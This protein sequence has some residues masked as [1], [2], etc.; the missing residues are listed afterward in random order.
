MSPF[1]PSGS[2]S[3]KK[4]FKSS[5]GHHNTGS[6]SSCESDGR[7]FAALGG[8]RRSIA[9]FGVLLMGIAA[10][11]V[12]QAATYYVSNAGNDSNSGTS[13]ASPWKSIAKLNRMLPGFE[14]GRFRTA[15]GW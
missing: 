9:V 5:R 7:L 6:F 1:Q 11:R 3:P 4:H 2:L 15:K 13:T 10:G 12:A 8:S 14:A